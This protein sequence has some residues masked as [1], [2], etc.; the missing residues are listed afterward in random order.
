MDSRNLILFSTLY[1]ISTH[2]LNVILLCSHCVSPISNFF[3]QFP[4]MGVV[5]E[6][7]QGGRIAVS[8]MERGY[9]Y[10]D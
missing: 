3:G 4:V 8:D 9:F 7:D 6:F 10:K 5:L 1:F 2:R